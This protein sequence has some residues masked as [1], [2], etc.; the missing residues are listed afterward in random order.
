MRAL[1]GLSLDTFYLDFAKAFHTV[2]HER[3]LVKLKGYGINGK[4]LKWIRN[5]LLGRRQRVVVNGNYSSWAPVNSA[6]PQG[7]VMGPLLFICYVNGMPEVVHSAIR[8]F[9]NGTEIFSLVNDKEDRNK[10]QLDLERLQCWAGKR[11]LRFNA[12]KCKVRHLGNSNLKYDYQM[13]E[14]GTLVKLES[15]DCEKDLGVNVDKDLKFS[16]HAEVA[17]NKSNRIMGVIKRLFTCIDKEMFNCLFKSLVRPHLEY[18][19][20]VWSLW[21]K[22]DIQVIEN[23][24]R[25]A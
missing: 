10:L 8:M 11:Q 4:A 24:Q 13:E 1:E 15:S 14:S 16:K 3:L 20:V 19:N 6:I 7:S 12:T 5:F 17:S 21:Y 22:K 9:P 23:V 25:R 2:L 18:G